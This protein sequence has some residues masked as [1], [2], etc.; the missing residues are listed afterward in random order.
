M[1]KYDVCLVTLTFHPD[2]A[3]TAKLMYDL[4]TDM[5]GKGLRVAVF[6]QN[7]SYYDP[8]KEY[9]SFEQIKG[10]DVFRAEL[11]EFDKNRVWQKLLLYLVFARKAR[12][13]QDKVNTRSV[14]VVFPPLFVA[15]YVLKVCLKLSRSFVLILHDLDPD[16]AIRRQQISRYNPLAIILKRQNRFLFRNAS[17]IVVLGRDVENYLAKEYKVLPEK[18]SYIPNWGRELP[19]SFFNMQL[20]D[21]SVKE[22]FLVV[23]AGNFGESADL[24]T[25]FL[26]A[27]EIEKID[28]TIHFLFVGNGRKK[29]VW[30]D[31]VIRKGIRNI[32]FAEFLPEEQYQELLRRA[33][34]FVVTLRETSRGL[35]VPS[36]LYYYLSAGKP[37][38]AIVP[39]LSEIDLAIKEDGFG[40]VCPN[41]AVEMFVE[42]VLMIKND[43]DHYKKLSEN[44]ALSFRKNYSREKG[45]VKYYYLIKE[46]LQGD[47]SLAE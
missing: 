45:T 46:I 36:K 19:G 28:D 26:S 42:Q 22:P 23:Y 39:E 4:A 40:A 10:C 6:T 37:I 9:T 44:A 24:E 30:E 27:G 20:M 29:R 43:P 18:I 41:G 21:H 14:M 3:A 33:S 11:P 13:F 16:P 8:E 1:D 7:R 34:A 31:Y 32:R 25:L 47:Q 38:L 15:F 5:V 12:K 2:I 35:S 17:R